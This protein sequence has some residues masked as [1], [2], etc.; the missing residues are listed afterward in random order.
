MYD[1]ITQALVFVWN[2]AWNESGA[3]IMAVKKYSRPVENNSDPYENNGRGA[4]AK[5]VFTSL[6]CL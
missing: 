4:G 5:T 3:S 6:L 1:A 2:W